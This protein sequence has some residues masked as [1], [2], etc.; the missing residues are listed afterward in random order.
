MRTRRVLVPVSIVVLSTITAAL[1][2]PSKTTTPLTTEG[3][4]VREASGADLVADAVL[5][6]SGARIVLL[7]AVQFRSEAAPPKTTTIPAGK[8]TSA[9][10]AGLLIKPEATWVVSKIT[11]E[12]LKAA[13]ERSLS[14]VPEESAHFLQ[15]AGLK[16][17]YDPQAS[18]GHRVKSVTVGTEPIRDGTR[19]EVAM[20][21]DLAKGGSGYFVIADFNENNIVPDRSGTLA[22]AVSSFLDATPEL[23]YAKS[24]RLVPKEQ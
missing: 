6:A 23:K 5:R 13:L 9:D 21:E 4:R 17:E 22:T 18:S 24:D 1:A 19:Y 2:A 12:G 20:P 11:G 15:V 10:V 16:V 14:R 8:V 7:T 3:V